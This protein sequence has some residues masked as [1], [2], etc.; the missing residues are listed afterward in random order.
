MSS[1]SDPADSDF[2]WLSDTV[3]MWD[4]KS[5]VVN[6]EDPATQ[7]GAVANKIIAEKADA[8]MG[9]KALNSLLGIA[10]DTFDLEDSIGVVVNQP[11]KV[12]F[13]SALSAVGFNQPL[14]V[15]LPPVLSASGVLTSKSE[16]TAYQGMWNTK[17]NGCVHHGEP[18]EYPC[19]VISLLVGSKPGS[20]WE[21][22]HT[23]VFRD[24]LYKLLGIALPK[25]G[26]DQQAIG[27]ME[28]RIL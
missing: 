1:E 14:E 27:R 28:E 6:P 25:G 22:V 11:P 13:P 15:T 24:D 2:D 26:A 20:S 19:L 17:L 7:I 16:F 3:D 10:S 5:F 8:Q 23:F 4:P 12:P 21:I 9:E 18:T